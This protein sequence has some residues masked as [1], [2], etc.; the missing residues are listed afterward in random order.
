M[1][2][3]HQLQCKKLRDR[4][5]ILKIDQL[6]VALEDAI[7]N[8]LGRPSLLGLAIRIQ[9][10]LHARAALGAVGAFK[11]AAQA[12]VAVVAITIAIAWHLINHCA[13]AGSSLVRFLLRGSDQALI[14][15]LLFCKDRRQLGG[16]E[17]ARGME[18][19]D[20][21]L[22][23]S[24]LRMSH[25]SDTKDD[26]QTKKVLHIRAILPQNRES[27]TERKKSQNGTIFCYKRSLLTIYV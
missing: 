24:K 13:G 3:L 7:A 4:R 6:I 11:A 25:G 22:L 10:F 21:W 5:H 9:G 17:R 27:G 15:E 2:Q 19:R 26:E 20:L 8:H 12:G 16:S 14:G 1:R 23:V 18:R